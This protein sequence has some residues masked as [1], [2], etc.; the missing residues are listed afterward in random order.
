MIVGICDDDKSWCKRAEEFIQQYAEKVNENINVIKFYSI[1]EVTEYTGE[2]IDLIFME[3][4]FEPDQIIGD[5]KNGI[6]LGNFVNQKWNNCQVVYLTN[7]KEFITDAY[8]TDHIYY[9]LKDQFEKWIP[10]IF[11]KVTRNMEKSKGKYLF[12]AIGGKY[13]SVRAED[14]MYFERSGRVTKVVTSRGTYQ[15]WDKISSIYERISKLDFLRC[16]NS[17]IIYYPVIRE[18]VYD[19]I[20]LDNGKVIP[21]SRSYRKSV[22]QEFAKWALTQ[23]GEEK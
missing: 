11:K 14:V 5:K 4:V 9:V 12:S 1:N 20:T 21:I 6:W 18:I 8:R 15:I 3:T 13:F 16:H 23:W 7:Y 22:K 19:K 10:D 2:S 17:Y